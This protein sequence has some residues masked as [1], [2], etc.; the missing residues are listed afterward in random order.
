[1]GNIPFELKQQAREIEKNQIIDA[2]FSG[3]NDGNFSPQLT[4]ELAEEYYNETYKI[5]T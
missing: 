3:D 4:S 1:M 5:K 2:W